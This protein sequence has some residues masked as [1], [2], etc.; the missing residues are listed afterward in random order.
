VN[1][2]GCPLRCLCYKGKAPRR[3]IEVNHRNNGYRAKAKE[4]LNSEE[5]LR[6]RSMRPIEPEAVF[7]DI[8][9]DHGFRRF[10]LKGN[11]K[12]DVEFGLVAL[13]HNLRKLARVKTLEKP[14]TS[15]P[16]ADAI[17]KCEEKEVA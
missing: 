17:A 15:E 1:C 2:E 13:A 5:G 3:V 7:G 9:F 10:R 6:H 16:A 14:T 11:E 12:V 4:L 8:K